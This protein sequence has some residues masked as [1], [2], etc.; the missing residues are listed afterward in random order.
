MKT[1]LSTGLL[2]GVATLLSACGGNDSSAVVQTPSSGYASQVFVASSASYNPDIAVVQP[3]IDA[4]GV[5]LRPAGQPGHF[6]VLAGNKSYEYLGDVTGKVV[7]PCTAPSVLC[8]D[9]APLPDNTVTFPDFPLDPTT[10]GPDIINNH[11]T[12]VVFNSVAANFV[13]T[14][15]PSAPSTNT[16]PITAG[17]KF[18]FA[19]N[20]GA[21]YARGR[22]ASMR[23]AA[24]MTAP[25]RP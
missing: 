12:G 16:S 6:W 5:A 23:T 20:Y 19:T 1:A 4:W 3:L 11:A 22:N 10:G 2:V 21:I 17:A 14:Q 18:L 9:L 13:I 7:A 24:A 8:A 25:K 15:T